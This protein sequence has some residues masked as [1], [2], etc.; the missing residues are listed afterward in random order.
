MNAEKADTE[1]ER[2]KEK[3]NQVLTRNKTASI[4][5][6]N[7]NCKVLPE[8]HHYDLNH[9]YKLIRRTNHDIQSKP[10]QKAVPGRPLGR[11]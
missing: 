1:T 8:Y 3:L 6:L 10:C 7:L 2:N 11:R 4:T 9:C 5:L